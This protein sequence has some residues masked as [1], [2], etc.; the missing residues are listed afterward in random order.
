MCFVVRGVKSH[1]HVKTHAHMHTHVHAPRMRAHAAVSAQQCV[2]VRARGSAYGDEWGPWA[3][4]RVC[5]CAHLCGT[6]CAR[7]QCARVSL[8]ECACVRAFVILHIY[9]RALLCV[10]SVERACCG[11]ELC[12]RRAPWHRAA[13]QLR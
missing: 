4:L 8:H 11:N 5:L 1:T 12:V 6:G 3:C 2:R 7:A 10:F 9:A 13:G